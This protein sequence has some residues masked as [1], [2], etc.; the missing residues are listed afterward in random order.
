[1]TALVR[2]LLGPHAS[3]TEVRFCQIS[4]L[5]QCFDV[6]TRRRLIARLGERGPLAIDN[7]DAYADHITAFSLAGIRAVRAQAERR[8]A[9]APSA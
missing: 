8:A 7:L 3:D 1:M 9:H 6:M 4:I 2:E 5:S